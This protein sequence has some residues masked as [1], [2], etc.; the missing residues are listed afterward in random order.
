MAPWPVCHQVHGSW[1]V[2]WECIEK[3]KW[4]W[5][6][7]TVVGLKDELNET[8]VQRLQCTT[9]LVLGKEEDFCA[10]VQI[11]MKK[12]KAPGFYS[13]NKGNGLLKNKDEVISDYQNHNKSTNV[14]FLWWRWVSNPWAKTVHLNISLNINIDTSILIIMKLQNG[15]HNTWSMNFIF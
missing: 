15:L 3:W 6:L 4:R 10:W 7:H 8:E 14:R 1:H 5:A 11:L 2:R 9:T 13:A 12:L